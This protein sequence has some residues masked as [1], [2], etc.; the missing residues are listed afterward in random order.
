VPESQESGRY[1]V[2][3]EYEVFADSRENAVLKHL[4]DFDRF[5]SVRAVVKQHS[6]E[7]NRN[8]Y[9]HEQSYYIDGEPDV[10]EAMRFC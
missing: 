6:D 9:Q 1:I 8:V 10:K 2:T 7:P 4:T 5:C 3:V